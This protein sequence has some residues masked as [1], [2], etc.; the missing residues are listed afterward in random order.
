MTIAADEHFHRL[1]TLVLPLCEAA[2]RDREAMLLLYPAFDPSRDSRLTSFVKLINVFNSLLLA[3][4]FARNTIASGTWKE[5]LSAEEFSIWVREYDQ[6]LK[7]GFVQATFS[8]IESSLRV[9]LRALDPAACNGGMAEFKSIY[10]CLFKSKLHV[11]PVDGVELL[12][13]LRNI[14]NT[15]H[16][17][18]VFF[19]PKGLDKSVTWAG[20][21]YVFKHGVPV[22]F[23][24]WDFIVRAADAVRRLLRTV[25]EDDA[26]QA[27][28]TEI[29]E[30]C[31]P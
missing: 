3:S 15:V 25:V 17:N 12:D 9:F 6:I 20:Q 27:V 11:C 31:R 7:I 24:T 21:A 13:A 26:I 30:P 22:D 19:N 28:T 5:K 16:N 10:E 29:T 23:V 4:V 2:K 8:G 18:G 14:R 1:G